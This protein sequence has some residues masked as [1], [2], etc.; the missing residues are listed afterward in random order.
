MIPLQACSVKRRRRFA[1]FVAANYGGWFETVEFFAGWLVGG[2][3][4]GGD[5]GG[6]RAGLAEFSAAD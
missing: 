1:I 2:N 6:L 3:F 4:L 5:A